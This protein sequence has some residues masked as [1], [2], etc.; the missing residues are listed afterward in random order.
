MYLLAIHLMV[1]VSGVGI[2]VHKQNSSVNIQRCTCS[3]VFKGRF[4]LC[5]KTFGFKTTKPELA[6]H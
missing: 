3:G 6:S 1:V 4:Q 5:S 2:F